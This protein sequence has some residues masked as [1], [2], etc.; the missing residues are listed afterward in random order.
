M[1]NRYRYTQPLSTSKIITDRL[2][3][4]G[5]E[6]TQENLLRD[7]LSSLTVNDVIHIPDGGLSFT[8]GATNVEMMKLNDGILSVSGTTDSNSTTTGALL[9][10]GG[11][12][13]AKNI[14][15][16]GNVV[17]SVSPTIGSH[18]CNKTYVDSQL[19]T[20]GTGLC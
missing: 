7:D 13:V 2:W 16:G 11:V 19:V 17:S 15:C 14:Y 12:G 4:G 10:S 3:V 6:I 20:A 18:L 9:V 1:T 8:K 5:S